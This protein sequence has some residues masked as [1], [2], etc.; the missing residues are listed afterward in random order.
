MEQTNI[1]TTNKIKELLH[2][3]IAEQL[4]LSDFEN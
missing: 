4:I 3:F 2:T 1:K